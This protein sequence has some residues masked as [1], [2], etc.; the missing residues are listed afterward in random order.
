MSTGAVIAIVVVIV[1]VIAALAV[2]AMEM[3]RRRLRQQFG[4]EY[5][6]AVTETGSRRKAEAELA[7]RQRRVAKLDIRPLSREENARYQGEWNAIQERF[8]DTPTESV[9]QAATLVTTVMRVRGYPTDDQDEAMEALSVDHAPTLARYREARTISERAGSG[10]ATTDDLRNA[11][12]QYRELFHELVVS[13]DE[14][15]PGAGTSPADDAAAGTPAGTT[16]AGTPA[17]AAT[18]TPVTA[19][20]TAA[21]AESVRARED[22]P[23]TATTDGTPADLAGPAGTTPDDDAVT[24]DAVSSQRSTRG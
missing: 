1:V 7:A 8:V 10:A 11:M 6:R 23:D 20:A 12:L 21:P 5:D 3:R 9:T 15:A 2:G 19:D 16:A 18:D 4:P 24:G 14:A 13:P 22:L 17:D